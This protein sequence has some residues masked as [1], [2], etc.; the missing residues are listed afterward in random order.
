MLC[1]VFVAI[2][3]LRQRFNF[4]RLPQREATAFVHRG[5]LSNSHGRII[6]QPP[7]RQWSHQFFKQYF[8]TWITQIWY[9]F[10]RASSL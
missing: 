3:L 6:Q 8:T 9:D 10:Y 1:A 2:C 5:V 4:L 7:F